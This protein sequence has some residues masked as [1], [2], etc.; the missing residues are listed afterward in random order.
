MTSSGKATSQK[1]HAAV[2]SSFFFAVGPGVVAGVVPWLLTRWKIRRPV[3]GGTPARAAG[4]ALVGAGAMVLSHSFARFVVDGLGT[5]VP[6][7]P[8]RHLVI[9][10]LYR[11]V[12]N[13]M[14]VALESA[15]LGQALLLG[16]PVLLLY[17]AGWVV[18]AVTFVRLYEEPTLLRTF[19][20]E[21]ER[22]R[23]NVPG[24]LPRLRPW[25]PAAP[26]PVQD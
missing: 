20:A 19:E 12:R 17:G 16:R 25:R 14:Y 15:I 13:P 26:G 8:P 9:G 7:A 1:K 22:Y 24:W 5:P 23:R 4:A 11:H 6:L 3:P 10:G 21:Y 18:P 2:G